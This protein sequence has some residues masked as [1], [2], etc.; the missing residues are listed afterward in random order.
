ML[1]CMICGNKFDET[2]VDRTRVCNCGFDCH[3]A[4]VPC[5]NC[6]FDVFVPKELRK[7][8]DYFDKESFLSKLKNTLK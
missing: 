6:G 3:G 5:P 8:V 7:D 2:K 4:N 1:Q